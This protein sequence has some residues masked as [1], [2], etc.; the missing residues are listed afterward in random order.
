MARHAQGL[1]LSIVVGS[2][3][4]TSLAMA[5]ALLIAPMAR[6]VDLDG[7]LL[8]SQDRTPG[9]RFEGS[10]LYPPEPALWG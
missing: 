10:V 9:L 8:L 6:F 1:G 3:V 5:P 2:M 4:G 7:P